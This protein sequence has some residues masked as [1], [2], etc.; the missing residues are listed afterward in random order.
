MW[1]HHIEQPVETFFPQN[2]R[3]KAHFP[4][5]CLFVHGRA[6]S[7][8]YMARDGEEKAWLSGVL[9]REREKEKKEE[10]HFCALMLMMSE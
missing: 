3:L 7:V 6:P 4:L 9:Q 8:L 2:E 10:E 5:L 1:K